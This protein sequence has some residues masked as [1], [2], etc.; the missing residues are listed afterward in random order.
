MWGAGEITDKVEKLK[1]FLDYRAHL[2]KYNLFFFHLDKPSRADS[3][4]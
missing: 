1:E 2:P 3:A 4:V